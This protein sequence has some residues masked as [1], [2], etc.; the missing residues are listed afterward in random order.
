MDN[1]IDETEFDPVVDALVDL[2]KK[3]PQETVKMINPKKYRI[4]MDA[5]ANLGKVLSENYC[6]GEIEVK[7]DRLFNMGFVSVELPYFETTNPGRF[8]EITKQADNFEISPLLNGNFSISLSF[9]SM[10]MP[11]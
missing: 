11:L 7:I 6:E 5:A 1:I 10:L 4:M 8:F 2:L 3:Q 9:Q